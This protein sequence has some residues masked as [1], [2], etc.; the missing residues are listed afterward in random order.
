MRNTQTAHS[1]TRNTVVS[2]GGFD[3]IVISDSDFKAMS[4]EHRIALRDLDFS[5]VSDDLVR[6]SAEQFRDRGFKTWIIRQ[7][8]DATSESAREE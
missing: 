2:R 4:E 5:V 8:A 3:K 6:Q 1:I 7:G